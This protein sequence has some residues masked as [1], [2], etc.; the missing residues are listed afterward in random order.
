MRIIPVALASL[1]VVAP[2]GAQ[3]PTDSGDRA[4]SDSIRAAYLQAMSQDSPGDLAPEPGTMALLATGLIGMM[5][6]S[7][8]K[9]RKERE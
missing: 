7:I 5:G 6:A 4:E 2:L 9:R 8:R 3:F 1:L